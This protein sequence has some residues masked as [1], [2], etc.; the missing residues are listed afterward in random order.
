[1]SESHDAFIR[2]WFEEVWNQGNEATIDEMLAPDVV[3]HGIGDIPGSDL[4]GPDAFKQHFRR[5]RGAFPKMQVAV[6]DCISEGDRAVARFRVAARHEG[7]AFGFLPT[8]NQVAFDGVVIVQLREGQVAEAWNY[9][10]FTAMHQ[11][12][13]AKC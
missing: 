4:I 10:D 5:F 13:A 6:E 7:E 11:Q 1:M 8:F 12:L 9:I 2:R 3:V